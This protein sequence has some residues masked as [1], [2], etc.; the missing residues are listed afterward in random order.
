MA[1]AHTMEPMQ[2]CPSHEVPAWSARLRPEIDRLLEEV[3]A[4]LPQ[5]EV[6]RAARYVVQ[7][8]GHRWRG[9]MAVAAGLMF[10]PDAE[11]CALPLAAA[12]EV[13]HSASL[14]LDDLPSMDHSAMRRGRPCV[15]LAYPPW[16][17]D[18][19]PAFMVNLAYR[20][21]AEC[22]GVPEGCRLRALTWMAEMA[23]G[24]AYGQEL[25]LRLARSSA[26]VAELME[27]HALKSGS[28]FVA[29]LAGGGIWCGAGP[30]EAQ[31][32]REA[33]LKLGQAYQILDDISDGGAEEEK[34]TA[35]S[36]LGPEEALARGKRLRREAM[37]LLGHFGPRADR[38]CGLIGEM[39]EQAEG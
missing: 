21:V 6:V 23:T 4:A 7:G 12:L 5:T 8:A 37:D 39:M 2:T 36:L 1:V 26:S 13:V 14:V 22:S 24:M 30:E 3:F 38:L 16:V 11:T 18:L 15:H 9:L 19:L 28:L 20:T 27:C 17:V 35:L 31:V 29:A 25:D 34:C 33:G 32:L 10:R